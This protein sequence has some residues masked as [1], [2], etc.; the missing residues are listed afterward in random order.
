MTRL[1]TDHLHKSTLSGIIGAVF[2]VVLF[3]IVATASAQ[4]LAKATIDFPFVA[5]KTQCAPGAY[6]I[7]T[8]GGKIVLRSKEAKGSQVVLLPITRLGRHDRDVDT[9]LVFDKV[10]DK[11]LL[12]EIW[13]PNQ[14]GYL[15]TTTAGPHEHRVIGGSNP[16]K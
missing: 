15:L 16:H 10:G 8:S 12:S 5:G 6:E 7:D 2:A 4:T 9:E 3:G 13:L 1:A 14:D 11:L